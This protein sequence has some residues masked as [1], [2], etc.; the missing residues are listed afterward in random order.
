MTRQDLANVVAVAYGG[1]MA[2]MGS[3]YL[4]TMFDTW[5]GTIAL[6]GYFVL[7]VFRS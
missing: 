5:V 3:F 6:A 1:V 2:L 4:D 7:E